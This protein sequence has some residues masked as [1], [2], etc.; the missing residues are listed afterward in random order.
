MPKKN[1][2]FITLIIS[3]AFV[4][5]ACAGS[6]G[7]QGPQGPQGPA[8]PQGPTGPA[9][10]GLTEEQ[11]KALDT[12]GS[13]AAIQFPALD[14]VRRGCPACHALVDQETGKYTLPFEAHE[15]VEVRG[16][17]H[18]DVAPDGTSLAPAEEVK[19]TT[20]LQC[21]APGTGDRAGKGVIAP[22]A[23]RDIVHPAH[24][25]SQYFK[26]H[27]GGNCFTC[28]NVN[29]EGKWELLTEKVD[30]NEKGVPNPENLPIPGAVP[31]GGGEATSSGSASRGGRL[32]DN[33]LKEAGVET[34]TSDQPL[35]A[36]QTTNT[37][38]GVDTWRC[39]EC[40]GWDYLG[41]AGAYGSGSHFTGFPGVTGAASK[42]TDEIVTIL[43]GGSNA[44][45]NF[46]A[47]GED[48]LADLVVFLQSG[49]VDVTPLIEAGTKSAVGGDAA[50]GA[51][52]F[53]TC[54]ACHAEDG[55]M[56]NFGSDEEPEYVGTI[57]LDNP[58]EFL[59]KV[60]AGQPGTAMPAAI[61]GGW[62]LEDL[63]DL[64]TF[65]QTLPVEA[66]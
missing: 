47:M 51:E 25:N 17:K 56:L 66:P 46:S 37:R 27:Y 64:L 44:D 53:A 16:R 61:D 57:A 26:L 35:W 45:H 38:S 62:S 23:L 11:T 55:R 32:Y 1:L 58:W 43:S 7:P 5:A 21:H 22:L 30:V 59:H 60:R 28:H 13:L 12:A 54:A 18:P 65:A 36:S 39:K 48:A 42:T 14:E 19:V 2:L 40:H 31:I 52:L 3:G 15:R 63:L 20:C 29:G 4:L 50:H 24:M 49:L 41:A 34:P 10:E 33:W 9:G 8:G 6:T